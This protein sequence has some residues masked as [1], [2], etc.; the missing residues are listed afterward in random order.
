MEDF[1]SDS[2][3]DYTSYWRDWVGSLFF[4]FFLFFSLIFFFSVAMWRN[5]SAMKRVTDAVHSS[6]LQ[7]ETNIS[8][9]SMRSI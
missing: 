3:S 9:T 2:E 8:V 1:N 5:P 6:F 4:N 7:G